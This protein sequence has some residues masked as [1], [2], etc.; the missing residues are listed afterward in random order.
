MHESQLTFSS[1]TNYPIWDATITLQAIV[2]WHK[3]YPTSTMQ[4]SGF[5][6]DAIETLIG[7]I[8]SKDDKE[9]S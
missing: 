5:Q 4:I 3:Q 8:N 6:F 1:D 7:C 2:D 9:T